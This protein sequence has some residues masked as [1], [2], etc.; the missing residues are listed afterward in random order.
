MLH[1]ESQIEIDV[2]APLAFALLCDPVR[3]TELNPKVEAVLAANPSTSS[4][5]VGSRIHYRLRTASGYR[6]FHCTVTAF[7]PDRL[8]EV[9][10][11]TQPSFRVRQSLEPTLYGCLL[12]HDEWIDA[13]RAQI[14]AGGRERPLPFLLRVLEAAVGHSMPTPEEMEQGQQEILQS[15]LEQSLAEWLT[16]IKVCLESSSQDLPDSDSAVVT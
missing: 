4:L 6:A 13:G 15:E 1:L 9:V 5:G 11:D 3:K 7:E 12:R 10:S 8:L 2:P 16:N 14:Q